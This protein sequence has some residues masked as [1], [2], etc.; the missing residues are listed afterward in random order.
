[1]D[2][3]FIKLSPTQNMTI[4]VESPVPRE[5]HKEVAQELMKYD[6]VFAEQVGFI[7]APEHNPDAWGR[8]QM[9]GGEFCGN[10]TMSL[11]AV[12]AMG[13]EI[14]DG[15]PV[16]V[17]LEVSG[18]DGIINVD[19]TLQGHE[20]H[21]SVEMP[22]PEKIE[23]LTL[24]LKGE[25]YQINVVTLEGITHIIVD[26]DLVSGDKAIFA[27][28]ALREWKS[29]FSAE[30]LGLI[31][32]DRVRNFI[33]PLIYVES[34]DSFVWERGCGSGSAALGAYLAHKAQGTVGVD[35]AQPGGVITVMSGYKPDRTMKTVIS[36][37]V[38]LVA[39]GVAYL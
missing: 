33:K 22:R 14:P 37:N 12:L 36:G 34:T 28:R 10:A 25:D 18:L 23:Q 29:N 26:V 5:L 1:M 31:L 2:I 24:H 6:G 39:R 35:I 15:R 4:L 21:C 30:A 16:D 27:E 13:R 20:A 9:M 32:Y 3:Q 11:A 8:L 17:P 19:L 7:E 38:K